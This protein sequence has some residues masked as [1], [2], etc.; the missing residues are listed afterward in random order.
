MSF[1]QLKVPSQ[2]LD[3]QHEV[4]NRTDF[5]CLQAEVGSGLQSARKMCP[6]RQKKVIGT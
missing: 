5:R 3:I 4:V 6:I 2:R 1:V